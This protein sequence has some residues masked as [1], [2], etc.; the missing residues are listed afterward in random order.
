MLP[1]RIAKQAKPQRLMLFQ[2]AMAHHARRIRSNVRCRTT[3][4]CVQT[5][6]CSSCAIR[7][8]GRVSQARECH[9]LPW[10]RAQVQHSAF[11]CAQLSAIQ[12]TTSGDAFCEVHDWNHRAPRPQSTAPRPVPQT[13][14]HPMPPTVPPT[15]PLAKR[16]DPMT[17]KERLVQPGAKR[18]RFTP[19]NAPP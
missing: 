14:P 8:Q 2:V 18:A 10:W 12:S 9:S 7:S 6:S 5:H 15:V 19:A 17:K 4:T 3:G 1:Q 11:P 16:P 13:V